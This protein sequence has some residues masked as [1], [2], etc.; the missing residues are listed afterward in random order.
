MAQEK[1]LINIV[2]RANKYLFL[3]SDEAIY[4][5]YWHKIP[6]GS[7]FIKWTKKEDM[8]SEQKE[9]VKG[10]MEKYNIS[11]REARESII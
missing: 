10:L 9:V 11:E 8:G 4:H 5:Y 6:R 2:N 1:D 3:L 7:R